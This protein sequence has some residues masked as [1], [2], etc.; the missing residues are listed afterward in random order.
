MI[1]AG[2][3]A[4]AIHARRVGHDS[5]VKADWDTLRSVLTILRDRHPNFPFLVN[6]DFYDRQELQDLSLQLLPLL[7]Q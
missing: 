5:I 7:F 4:V 6:G 3:N 1:S 2:A